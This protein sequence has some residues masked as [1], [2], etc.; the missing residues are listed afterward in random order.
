M[1][2]AA[3][4]LAGGQVHRQLDQPRG[5]RGALRRRAAA[6]AGVRR[7]RHRPDHRRGGHGQD[8]RPQA[9][10]RPAHLRH[11]R[12]RVRPAPERPPLRPADLHDLHR[13]R[14][15]PPARAARRSTA[16]GASSAELPGVRTPA[17]PVATSASASSRRRGTCSTA[18]SCTTRARP[19][20]TP[21]SCTP[22]ASSRCYRIDRS[23]REVAED[24]IFDRRRDGLRPAARV[25]CALFAGRAGRE[26]GRAHVPGR[27]RGAPEAAHHRRRPHGPRRR[28]RRSALQTHAPLDIINDDPAGRHEGGRR[29]VRLAARCSCRSCCS[30]PR[31]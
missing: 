27:R 6:R 14:G 8:R 24:L 21:P 30:R 15:R 25:S 11:L 22:A 1:I 9:R 29:A 7:R 19:A 13:Q 31:R 18:C 17:G 20:S 3:L 28:P 10:D 5:R 26:E 23:A 16:S 12:R 2:E 4:K